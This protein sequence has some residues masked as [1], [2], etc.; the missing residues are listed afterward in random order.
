NP[1]RKPPEQIRTS[2]LNET[3]PGTTFEKVKS[4]I[5][6]NGWNHDIFIH[7]DPFLEPDQQ[8]KEKTKSILA[9]LGWFNRMPWENGFPF[10]CVVLATWTFFR[11]PVPGRAGGVGTCPLLTFTSQANRGDGQGSQQ[12]AIHKRLS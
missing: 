4:F 10:A 5:K 8:E 9:K 7:P 12:D 1:L 3:P 2:L 6:S 11:Y